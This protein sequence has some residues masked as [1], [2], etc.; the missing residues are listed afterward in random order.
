[1]ETSTSYQDYANFNYI[2]YIKTLEVGPKIVSTRFVN[3]QGQR[4]IYDTATEKEYLLDAIFI[5][6]EDILKNHFTDNYD[7][8]A[9]KNTNMYLNIRE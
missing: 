7:Y 6:K 4:I 9:N 2:N 5:G 8:L 1:M 3:D